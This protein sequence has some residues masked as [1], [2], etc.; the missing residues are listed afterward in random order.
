M[1]TL[2]QDIH[3]A[4]RSFIRNPMFCAVTVLTLGLGIGANA[5][6]FTL[7]DVVLLQT[8]PVQDSRQLYL[9]KE[10]SITSE[11]TRFSYPEYVRL[12]KTLPDSAKLAAMTPPANFYVSVEDG[13]PE[14]ALGQLV[15][16]E[17]FSVL[18][19]SPALG[20]LLTEEDN[21]FIDAH[22]VAVISY[23]YWQRK[24]AG[25]T[26]VLGTKL[27]INSVPFTI[28]GV[29]AP[30]FFGAT[31][32]RNLSFWIPAAMQ[33]AVG[34]KQLFRSKGGVLTQPFLVQEKIY[35]LQLIARLPD[36]QAIPKINQELNHIYLNDLSEIE[37]SRNG[38]QFLTEHRLELESGNR[39]FANLRK[40]LSHPLFVLMG[41]V[42]LVLL[43]ICANVATLLLIRT[44]SRRKELALRMSLG[45]SRARVIRQLFTES[46]VLA[47]LGAIVGLFI[48][49]W[50]GTV[51]MWSSKG[52]IPV[53][54]FD[55]LPNFHVL[56]FTALIG[57]I[58]GLVFGMVPAFQIQRTDLSSGVKIN[59]S[60]QSG[61]V[62]RRR[63]SYSVPN[64][65]VALQIAI[66]LAVL[67]EAL[68]FQRTLV[69]LSHLDLGFNPSGIVTAWIDPP[70][71][72]YD[73]SKLRNLYPQLLERLEGTPG[74][75]SA[76][77]STCGIADGCRDSSV[78]YPHARPVAP[79]EAKSAQENR[80]SIN[81]FRTVDIAL[82]KGREFTS[83]DNEQGRK[84]AIVN[85]SFARNFLNGA[86]PIGQHFGY[87]LERS[88]EFE[89][90]GVAHNAR[91]NGLREAAPPLIYYPLLQSSS[92]AHSISAHTAADPE[93]AM[94]EIRRVLKEVDH[95]LPVA[96][97]TTLGDLLDR[98][99]APER[100]TARLIT[101]FGLI[102]LALACLGVYGTITYI[103][104]QRSIEFG[105]R[106]ALGASRRH[107]VALVIKQTLLIAATGTAMGL[108]LSLL[109]TKLTSNLIS[110]VVTPDSTAIVA[111]MLLLILI[112]VIAGMSPAW[113][114]SRIDPN[115][116]L[117][118]E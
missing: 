75:V 116:T 23:G 97:I 87:S 24:L 90:I 109:L 8:L 93:V 108:V 33:T 6:M 64:L 35:W 13:Q 80:V 27:R 106:L 68:V 17:Y 81:Y 36:V 10:R 79:Y 22:P 117:R 113:R 89:I 29:T 84:V 49:H 37:N 48:A 111:V 19:T 39:G 11:E 2:K 61:T 30:G 38:K 20:R 115:R 5:A 96:Y 82:I 51:L 59:P 3:F 101:F 76:A 52:F 67:A 54:R 25:S 100:G 99:L 50:C 31:P 83:E 71:T 66:S 1:D 41:M 9:I 60:A 95:K 77:L 91:T 55:W 86:D 46:M 92:V 32:G 63:L 65:L 43:T 40:N 110:G 98:N 45:A 15:S 42:G 62:A 88:E 104:E 18:K 21:Q 78:I 74:I 57:T 102:A 73:Q 103:V 12:G 26:A 7:L 107:L 14:G 105:I 47:L 44:R 114:A 28:I 69:H 56:A 34:Y 53:F 70:P 58:A 94:G 118:Q 85:E 112:M 16:K 4:I 72:E